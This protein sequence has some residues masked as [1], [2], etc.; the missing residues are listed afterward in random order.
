[1]ASFVYNGDEIAVKTIGG[2]TN[3]DYPSVSLRN[4]KPSV[5]KF[6]SAKTLAEIGG[7][8]CTALKDNNPC[9][10]ML[11]STFLI[12][13][14]KKLTFQAQ[15]DWVSYEHQLATTGSV[16]SPL[17]LVVVTENEEL[18]ADLR[19]IRLGS[20]NE[21][22]CL[23]LVLLAG[24]RM[25]NAPDIHR[26][27]IKDKITAISATYPT[28]DWDPSTILTSYAKWAADM[29]YKKIV[30]AVDMFLSKY[31]T[32]SLALFRV[33]TLVSR[34]NQCSALSSCLYLWGLCGADVNKMIGF[35]WV[36]DV[37]KE[38]V[39]LYKPEE[40]FSEIDSYLPYGSFF[41]LVNRSAYSAACNPKFTVFVHSIGSFLL[42]PRS[43]NAYFDTSATAQQ[44]L[45]NA[46]I[47]AYMIFHTSTFSITAHD[48]NAPRARVSA[49]NK[50]M[51]EAHLE[52]EELEPME[53]ETQ[54]DFARRS[55]QHAARKIP[56]SQ[57]FLDWLACIGAHQGELPP[58][59]SAWAKSQA[60]KITQ[61][62]NGTMG[63]HIKQLYGD[64]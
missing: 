63:S 27:T 42:N 8:V 39:R 55:L 53:N 60:N 29:N 9:D 19:G 50:S 49:V 3:G 21:I 2:E 13:W 38:I 54:E 30:A 11:I 43:L 32:H 15:A 40:E 57:D 56:T 34:Y 10:P 64:A 12:E 28:N 41:G 14:A 51:L 45:M 58:K 17:N 47:V 7:F 18:P 4:G 62:R 37:V 36:E 26:E 25:A 1:M 52:T 22:N 23:A 48:S 35:V 24:A 46:I 31:S 44:I 33:A 5:R 16:V 59:I 20:E 6:R 61:P